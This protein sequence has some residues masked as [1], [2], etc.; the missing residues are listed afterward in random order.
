MGSVLSIKKSGKREID[1][2]IVMVNTIRIYTNDLIRS[3]IP[4]L[5]ILSL[6]LAL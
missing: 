1:R 4:L 2:R 6:P 3:K 5:Q